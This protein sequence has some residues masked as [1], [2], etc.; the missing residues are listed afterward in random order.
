[1]TATV[2]DNPDR[3]RFEILI[4]GEVAGTAAYRLDDGAV[5]I[6]HTEVDQRY[7]GQGVGQQLAQ[8]ALE[9]LR[10]QGRQLVPQCSFI[11]RYLQQHPEYAD[12]VA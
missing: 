10:Q 5:R 8:G 9:T 2:Q 1:M 7:R 11:Q 4:D 6:T 3:R 12:L